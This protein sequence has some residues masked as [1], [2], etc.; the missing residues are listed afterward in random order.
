MC[1]ECH[2]C[3]AIRPGSHVWRYSNLL[4]SAMTLLHLPIQSE[5]WWRTTD[6]G[7][8]I[9]FVATLVE[10]SY[11]TSYITVLCNIHSPPLTRTLCQGGQLPIRV[12]I[13]IICIDNERP[14]IYS[15]YIIGSY[16]VSRGLHAWPKLMRRMHAARLIPFSSYIRAYADP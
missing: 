9:Y 14:Y 6:S 4:L 15:L 10:I 12:N 1:S 7:T 11:W 2:I 5:W 16:I 3:T 13:L 8:I